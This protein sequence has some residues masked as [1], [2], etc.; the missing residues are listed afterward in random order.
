M[1]NTLVERARGGDAS[2]YEELVRRYQDIAVRTAYVVTGDGAEAEDIAQDAFVKAFYALNGFQ[3]GAPFRPWLLR[4]VVNE[5]R[6]R[7]KAS[8]RRAALVLRAAEEGSA[9]ADPSPEDTAL[10]AE[11]RA[12]L[13]RA[14]NELRD[15]DHQVI[16][17]RYFLDLSEAE[18]AAA[19]GCAR[20]TVKSRLARAL[21]R[22]RRGLAGTDD[23]AAPEDSSG[24]RK[25]SAYG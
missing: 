20:G 22:L 23:I 1:E 11:R 2:A 3:S 7:R 5:A 12:T 19:L 13:L 8:G 10:A 16:A 4:I 24:G 17:Y 14:L 9:V 6:N 21:G 15:D 25:G 18:M